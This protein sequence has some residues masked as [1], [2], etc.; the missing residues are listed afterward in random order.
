VKH[1]RSI[2]LLRLA[3]TA[4]GG[5]AAAASAAVIVAG[6]GERWFAQFSAAI[7]L[8]ALFFA[9]FVFVVSTRQSRN[10]V[11]WLMAGSSLAA[12]W[13]L[14]GTAII[15]ILF[16][17]GRLAWVS[18]AGMPLRAPSELP[19]VAAWIIFLTEPLVILAI[20]VPV[21]LGLLLFPDGRLP[22]RK[23]RVVRLL[24]TFS[25]LGSALASAWTWRPWTTAPPSSVEVGTV[26]ALFFIWLLAVVL[27]TASLVTRLPHGSDETRQQLKWVFWG[28]SLFSLALVAG[29]LLEGGRYDYVLETPGFQAVWAGALAVFLLSY[30]IAVAKYRLY[31]IDVVI[32]RTVVYGTLAV[33]ITSF[34]VVTVVGVGALL[35]GDDDSPNLWLAI[36]ATA[37]VALAFEPF[38]SRLDELAKRLVYGRK[39]TAYRVLSEFSNKISANDETLLEQVVRSL[40]DGT[41]ADVAEVWLVDQDEFVRKVT[42]SA[43]AEVGPSSAPNIDRI[44]AGDV[45]EPIIHHGRVLGA[46]TLSIS[47]GQTLLRSDL[48][49]LSQ[50]ASA[51]GLALRNLQLGQ[52]L[53]R[54]VRELHRSRQRVVT[55][56][57]ET[58]RRLERDL[59]DGAQQRLLAVVLKL[60]LAKKQAEGMEKTRLADL[61]GKVAW[62]TEHTIRS[63]REFAQGVHSPLLESGGLSAALASYVQG[64]PIAVTFHSPGVTRYPR[65]V[66]TTVYACVIEALQNVI[67]HADAGSVYVSLRDTEAGVSFEISD[68]GCGFEPGFQ[69]SGWGLANMGDRIGA[70]DGTLDVVAAPGRGTT[71]R[72]TIPLPDLELAP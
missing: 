5:L 31:G 48:R 13:T 28:G 1:S 25:I 7:A 36:A 53:H 23:W 32:S 27:S 58:R 47:G 15:M 39:A 21:T 60:G 38:R 43:E 30:G 70:L 8:L 40:V 16:P 12:G 57:D 11:V 33:F 63:L 50:L 26:S 14:A 69:R 41:T 67:K 6:H 37:M 22:S 3:A 59:H 29:G 51:L 45:V 20:F 72:G 17:G 24:A 71:V 9:G 18:A 54:Q 10:L 65:A 46:L 61:L 62:R 68:D 35:G 2:R 44:P 42:S 66:E 34:Y 19:R 49:L 55:I 52:E 4:G 64:L 56:Q